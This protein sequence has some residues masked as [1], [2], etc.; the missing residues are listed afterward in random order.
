MKEKRKKIRN[1]LH[2]L[3]YRIKCA[4]DDDGNNECCETWQD[5]DVFY[6]WYES[7]SLEQQG[8]CRFCGLP[9][10]T[11]ESWGRLFR[12]GRRGLQ[13]EVGRKD[14]S[15]KY[16][17]ENCILACYPCNNAKSDVFAFEEFLVIGQVIGGLKKRTT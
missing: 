14:A 7:Q 8:L 11:L 1:S 10:N 17:P 12:Q 4:K 3:H 9:G 6:A 13:L 2:S 15:G 5:E 16:S